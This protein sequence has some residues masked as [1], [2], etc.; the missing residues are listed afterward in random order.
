MV[1]LPDLDEREGNTLCDIMEEM[2]MDF[3]ESI[4]GLGSVEDDE[5]TLLV[6]G[7]D[8]GERQPS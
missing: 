5:G 4:S 3:S 7:V 2:R 6:T 8:K 1:T